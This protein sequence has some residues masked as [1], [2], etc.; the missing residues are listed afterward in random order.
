MKKFIKKLFKV[1][2][3]SIGGLFLLG[4]IAAACSDEEVKEEKTVK[5]VEEKVEAEPIKKKAKD[6]EEK[7]A[8]PAV[9]HKPAIVQFEKQALALDKEFQ[10][11]W[12]EVQDK[13][14]A[15]DRYGAYDASVKAYNEA[16]RIWLAYS[17][18]EID[19]SL[20]NDV[21]KLLDDAQTDLQLNY[22]MKKQ[23]IKA[24][25]KGLD[26]NKPSDLAD[27]KEKLSQAQGYMYSGVA[28]M[29]EAKIK[30]GIIK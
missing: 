10:P 3:Y 25:Q 28:K 2:L 16:E 5:Q 17:K 12:K 29:T 18:I 22:Y 9:D 14:N 4:I 23:A 26:E 7:K 8:K 20:P 1:G 21:K 6:N 13:L 24:M 19:D 30:V 27:F 15:S 11:T